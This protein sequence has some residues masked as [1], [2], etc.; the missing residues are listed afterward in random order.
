MFEPEILTQLQKAR[1]ADA[2]PDAGIRFTWI[3]EE[4]LCDCTVQGHIQFH[5]A[6]VHTGCTGQLLIDDI[7]L[8]Q[9]CTC[10]QG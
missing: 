4:G 3:A 9:M 1:L 8:L 10:C 6:F 2:A 7:Y 5:R